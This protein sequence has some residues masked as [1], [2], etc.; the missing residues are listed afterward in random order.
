MK[1]QIFLALFWLTVFCAAPV[2]A[3]NCYEFGKLVEKTYNFKPSKISP[4]ERD[5][6]SVEMDIVWNKVKANPQSLLPCLRD[7]LKNR[8]NDSFF[9]FDASNLLIQ[10]DQSKEAKEILIDSFAKADFD[11]IDLRYWLP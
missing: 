5:A 9:R 8:T 10:L 4:A 6:K 2:F 7:A 1:R 3:Q 11:D